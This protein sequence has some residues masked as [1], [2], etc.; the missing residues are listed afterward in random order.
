MKFGAMNFPIIPVIDEIETFASLGFDYL[1]LTMDQPQAH[2]SQVRRDKDAILRAL[3]RY[4]MG[5][6]C[7]L[8]SFVSTA[9]LTESI[10]QASLSEMLESLKV[11]AQ[12]RATKVVVHPSH[13]FGMGALVNDRSEKYALES[14]EAIVET[15]RSLGLVLCLENMF[16][17]SGSLVEPEHFTRIFETFTDLKLTLDT[18]HANIR[19]RGGQK[20]IEFIDKFG[21]RIAHVH[22]SDNFGTDDNHLPLGAG[23]VD[24]PRVVRALK[25]VGYDETVT[26]EVFSRDRDYV[27]ISRDKFAAMLETSPIGG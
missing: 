4:G 16:P 3:E 20:V 27:R 17:R 15:G 14:L 21:G 13:V 22:A 1:E 25:S 5:L 23:N 18:G 12:L 10:R 7:H 9:D 19:G 2:Y 26:F 8:P 11:A 6:V 24:F